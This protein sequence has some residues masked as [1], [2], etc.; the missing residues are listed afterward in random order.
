MPGWVG[1]AC[2]S[3]CTVEDCRVGTYRS[4]PLKTTRTSTHTPG[5][6]T[7][8]T[9]RPARAPPRRRRRGTAPA[10]AGITE[11]LTPRI[12]PPQPTSAVNASAPPHTQP[13]K[14]PGHP[15]A[16]AHTPA[17]CSGMH[18]DGGDGGACTCHLLAAHEVRL[19]AGPCAASAAP[20]A[21]TY[22]YRCRYLPTGTYQLPT[23][24]SSRPLPR[25]G[26]TDCMYRL[27]SRVRLHPHTRR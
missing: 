14:H 26:R 5:P 16:R 23:S 21:G 3:V 2:P 1:L 9:P 4:W 10:H 24:T 25:G 18:G 20:P 7:G 17:T 13:A 19:R 15:P 22:R 8:R 12:G 27:H 6:N 11:G